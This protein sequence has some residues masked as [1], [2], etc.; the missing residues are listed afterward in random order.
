MGSGSARLT[1][2]ARRVFAQLSQL[3][4]GWLD[5]NTRAL[6]IATARRQKKKTGR[7]TGQNDGDDEGNDRADDIADSSVD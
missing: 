5:P 1:V 2:V 4:A 3:A 7:C 6:C